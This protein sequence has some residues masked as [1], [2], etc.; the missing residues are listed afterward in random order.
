MTRIVFIVLVMLFSHVLNAQMMVY[1]DTVPVYENNAKL[2]MP[3]AGGINFSSFTQIDLNSDGKKDIVGYDKIS[4]S[5]GR[6]RAYLNAGIPGVSKY[7]HSY[8]YQEQ[9]PAVNDWALFFDYN[10]DGKADMFTYTTGGIKV[11]KNT[12]VGSALSFALASPSLT[13]DYNPTGNPSV[14]NLYCN[15]VALPGIADIDNDGDLDVLSYSVFGTKIEFH[16]NMSQE[17][18]GHSDSLIFDMVDDC[19]G[20]INEN[21]CQVDLNNCPYMK[22]YNTMVKDSISKVLHAGSCIMCF[23]RDGDGDKE[24]IMGDISCSN[25]FFV[26]NVGSTS[27]AHIGDTTILYPNYPAKASTN[28]IKLNS[29]P[30]TFYLDVDNDGKKDLIASPNAISGSEN[31][32]SVW[33]YK[34][35]SATPTVNFVFQKKNFLQ[36]DMMEFGEGA[37]PVLFDANGDGKKDLIVGNLGYYT[38]NTNKSKLAYYQNIGTASTPS[39]SLITKDY[40]SLSTYNIFSMAPTFGDLDNDGDED[41]LIGDINGELH[42]FENIAGFGTNAVFSNHVSRYQGI[43]V[44]SFAYPQLYDVDLNGTLDL[45]IGSQNGRLDFRKNIGTV[46]SPSFTSQT[47]FFGKVDVKQYGWATG[48]SMPYMFRDAGVTKLLVGSEMGNIY[49]YNNIDGNLSGTFNKVDTTLFHIN[50]GPRCAPF[51]EDVTFDGKRDLFL[52]NYAGGL[53]FFNSTNVNGVGIK[54]LF[55]EENISVYPNPASEDVTIAIKDN[56][57]N[58]LLVKCYDVLGKTVYETS[59]YNKVIQID[60]SQF[61]KGIYFIQLQSKDEQMMKSVTR[62]VVV[63]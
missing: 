5:G 13:S 8:T 7:L 22:L 14:S 6:L 36:E 56:T 21:N 10:N 37:Y 20:D 38:V 11:Y 62:K 17:L 50:E 49:L 23:D 63:Q 46:S 31:Y 30:C 42:Y 27:N 55:N 34:N 61:D 40:Q 39:F 32:Q 26:E 59:T 51:Y 18:Y 44:G 3:W 41:L 25:V 45:V 53:A 58:E 19:W 33:Y 29:F 12:S 4:G 35:T 2:S 52:G 57:Y 24:L 47:S 15:S 54:E 1:R 9:F 28:V 60:V 16:K 43:D 48:F